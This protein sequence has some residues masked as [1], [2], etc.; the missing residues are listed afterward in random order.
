M[1]SSAELFF[2]ASLERRESRGG[3]FRTDF[4]KKDPSWLAWLIVS[5]GDR[6]TVEFSKKPVPVEKFKH[7]VDSFY[8]DQ[9][10]L[11]GNI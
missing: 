6:G 4:P 7:P 10:I 1:A 2:R 9:F 8:S 11:E 5:G 3:H